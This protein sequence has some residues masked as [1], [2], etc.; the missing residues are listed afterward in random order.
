MSTGLLYHGFGIR[1]Y[2]YLRTKYEEGA[3][4]FSI[5]QERRRLRC[6]GCGSARIIRR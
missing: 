2:K 3:V 5:E 4:I 1:G 6:A